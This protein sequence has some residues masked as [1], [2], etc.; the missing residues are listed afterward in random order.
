MTYATAV[1]MPD[2]LAHCAR[3]G[4]QAHTSAATQAASETMPDSQAA[5]PQ[6]ERPTQAFYTSLILMVHTKG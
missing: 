1:A 3:A 6:W 2:P 5:A 4:N